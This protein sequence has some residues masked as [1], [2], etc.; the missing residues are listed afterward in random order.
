[1][2]VIRSRDAPALF[3]RGTSLFRIRSS[4]VAQWHRYTASQVRRWRSCG[5]LHLFVPDQ[6]FFRMVA[7]GT[8]EGSPIMIG[9]A[10][11]DAREPHE[12]SALRTRR[13]VYLGQQWWIG[14]TRNCHW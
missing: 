9:L 1:M 3:Q 10:G 2:C 11:L 8:F 13:T 4:L 6:K 14:T 7:I 5:F 12:P